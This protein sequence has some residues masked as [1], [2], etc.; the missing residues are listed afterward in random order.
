[1][2]WITRFNGDRS[3]H[4]EQ[5]GGQ[6]KGLCGSFAVKMRNRKSKVMAR[7]CIARCLGSYI[8]LLNFPIGLRLSSPA[9]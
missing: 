3:S 4:T 2:G 5:R 7:G 1:M 6:Y 8:R 9:M